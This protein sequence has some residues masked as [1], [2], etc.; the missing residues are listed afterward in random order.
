MNHIVVTLSIA[1]GFVTAAAPAG[2][3]G[4]VPDPIKLRVNEM[5]AACAAAGGTLGNQRGPN[6][7]VIPRD[8]NGDGR[9]DFLVTEGGFPC[10]GAPMALR[11]QGQARL[12][13]WV[14]DGAGNARLMFDDRVSG[15]RVVEGKPAA[16]N[17]FRTG[18]I[19]GPGRPK[20]EDRVAITPAG[21]ILTPAD[22]RP[23]GA[24][25]LAA[26]AARPV[27]A[28]PSAAARPATAKPGALPLKRG[29]Y[30]EASEACNRASNAT[31]SLF[32]GDGMNASRTVCTFQR[33]EKVGATRFRVTESC[34][35]L[36]GWG[37]ES[38]PEVSTVTYDVPNDSRFTVTWPGGS[39]LTSRH[40]PQS[41][42][43]EP[44]RTND[45][46]DLMR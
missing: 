37:H 23:G 31:V 5:V 36:G 3:Q 4:T 15:H 14:G 12:Q 30:V 35:E 22:G 2:A 21:V 45:I 42:M 6:G 44:F 10:A 13:L 34:Q 40:C 17:I 43:N 46:S 39:S 33:V 19:C 32:T 1:A 27:A 7:F 18:A 25:A 26:P 11:P 41:Q 8:F 38:P 28:S 29:Y 20:C 16:L 24:V 9:T